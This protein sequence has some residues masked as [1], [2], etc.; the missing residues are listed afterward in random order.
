MI[1]APSRGPSLLVFSDDW[2]R[3]PSSCQH[4]VRRLIGRYEVSWVNTIGTRTPKL[5]LM[6]IKRGW[7]KLRQWKSRKRADDTPLPA[8]LRVHNPRMWPW[9]SH[10]WDRRLN[11]GLLTKQLTDVVESMPQP[12]V[13]VTTLPIT[14]DLVGRLPVAKWRYYCV[15]DFSVWPGL[16]GRTLKRMDDDMLRNADSIIVVSET[17][18][19]A[20][21]EQQRDAEMLTHGVDLEFWE[22]DREPDLLPNVE[23]PLVLFWG[24]IDRRL[25]SDFVNRLHEKLPTG[26][27]ML[28]GP[29]NDPDP[30]LLAL[31]RTHFHPAVSMEE[32]PGFAAAADVLMMP[33]ADLPVTRAMQPLKLKEYLATG[34]PVVVRDLPAIR[35]WSDCMDV[36]RTA[37]EFAEQVVSRIHTGVTAEQLE[38]RKRLREESW[39]AKAA[40]FEEWL[41][42]GIS[43]EV[44]T[45]P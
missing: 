41:F 29:Q 33:Y 42:A 23:R 20:A 28:V 21:A 31:P 18:R 35:E 26:T 16:D 11:R 3:H 15:D 39:D 25:D 27:L 36:S 32:L 24:C 9:F 7:E 6:T 30:E 8:G 2:G 14:A 12:V 17:L 5:D 34:K 19:D 43:K 40:K 13:A 4:L 38:A 1:D 10:G 44:A 45:A 37:D 22:A